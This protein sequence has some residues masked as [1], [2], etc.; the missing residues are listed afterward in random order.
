MV[1]VPTYNEDRSRSSVRVLECTTVRFIVVGGVE[2]DRSW[3]DRLDLSIP[4]PFRDDFLGPSK[5]KNSKKTCVF[6]RLPL[7]LVK[8]ISL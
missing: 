2:E 5:K 6:S 7:P 4:P 1:E 3:P 8:S